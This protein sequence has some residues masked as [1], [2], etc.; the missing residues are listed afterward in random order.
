MKAMIRVALLS[1]MIAGCANGPAASEVLPGRADGLASEPSA[2]ARSAASS[3]QAEV[4]QVIV[5]FRPEVGD[6]AGAVFLQS[7]SSLG[8]LSRVEFVRPMS[9]GAYVMRLYC[10]SNCDAA[11]ARLKDSGV[12]DL[13]ERDAI[14]RPQ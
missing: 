9:G 12:I 11:I 8:Q 13:I 2:A 10:A 3:T 7:L 5:M 4:A 14:A 6:P 1:S